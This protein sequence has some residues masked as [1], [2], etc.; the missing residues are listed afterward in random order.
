MPFIQC[1]EA[2][3]LNDKEDMHHRLLIKIPALPIPT[4]SPAVAR[5][6]DRT[7][8]QWPSGSSKVNDFHF[9]WKGVYHLLLAINSHLGRISHRF[10]DMA[11]CP[12]KNAHFSYP[13]SIQP[14]IWKCSPCTRSLKFC[15]P[16]L[17]TEGF[18]QNLSPATYRFATVH[19][20]QTTDGLQPYHKLDRK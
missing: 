1:F 14:R 10:R 4:R 2:K 16:R 9:I 12:L 20:L 3:L 6:A 8:C 7:G 13:P 18:V 11:S 15:M 17:M 19:P 5:I